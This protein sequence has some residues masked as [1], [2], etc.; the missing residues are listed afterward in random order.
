MNYTETT[1]SKDGRTI[2]LIEKNALHSKYNPEREAQS[3]AAQFKKGGFF[4]VL[5]IAGGYHIS[6][7]LQAHPQSKVVAVEAEKADI[8]FLKRIPE[9][10]KLGNDKRVR[11]A[12]EE[13][14][15]N[16]ITESYKPALHGDMTICALRS[17][18]NIFKERKEAI[19]GKI[20]DAL[21]KVSAD[22]S[23]QSHFGKIWQKNIFENLKSASESNTDIKKTISGIPSKKTAAIIAAGPT[24][25]K[26]VEKIRKDRVS[27]FVIATDTAFSALEERKIEA[28]CVVSVDGQSVSHAHFMHAID[29]DTIFVFDLCANSSAA[30]KVVEAG[31]KAIFT[32]SGHPLARYASTYTGRRAFQVIETG[33]G[34]VTIAAADFAIK[35]GFTHLEFFGADFSYVDGLP[36]AKGTYLDRIYRSDETMLDNFE[37]RFDKLMFRTELKKTG[38]RKFTTEILESYSESMESFLKNRGFKRIENGETKIFTAGKSA[39]AEWN[40]SDFDYRKFVEFYRSKMKNMPEEDSPEM[41]TILPLAAHMKSPILAHAKSLEYTEK[42]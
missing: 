7:L 27:Y 34:T 23:V 17:W 41:M 16:A 31:G 36:Y 15:E 25:D 33:S 26:T 11:F 37:T 42:L 21:K 24:L 22:Y 12:S 9:V 20:K 10:E 8:E 19:F 35:T 6:A 1:E 38:K 30:R 28:D 4:V 3:F 29:N 5:G 40:F 39:K 13:S 32:E 2:P 18:E 14:I